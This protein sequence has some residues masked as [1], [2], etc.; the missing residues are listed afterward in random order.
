[1]WGMKSFSLFA[2]AVAVMSVCQAASDAAT[3]AREAAQ[4]YGAAVRNCDMSWALDSMYPP[5]R[6]TYAD[7]LAPRAPGAEASRARRIQGLERETTVE[8]KARASAKKLEAAA[9]IL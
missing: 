9:A 3:S 8:A 2:A 5:L 7:T 6:L 4:Q 1:M